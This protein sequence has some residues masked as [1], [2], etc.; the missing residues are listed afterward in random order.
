MLIVFYNK[1][2]NKLEDLKFLL[3]LI[4][5]CNSN[6]KTVKELNDISNISE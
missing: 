1:S 2:L 5:S 3:K 4:F 6:F